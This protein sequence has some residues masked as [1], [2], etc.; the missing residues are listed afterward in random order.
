MARLMNN[1][2]E[3]A[4]LVKDMPGDENIE[5][6]KK[7]I[8]IRS[9]G[10]LLVKEQVRFKADGFSPAHNHDWGWKRY[11]H[12]AKDVNIIAA[13]DRIVTRFVEKGYSACS[14]L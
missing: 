12:T 4:R 5:W 1:G 10:W 7:F 6:R 9:N 14:S 13:C 8:S 11:L 2:F 3:L